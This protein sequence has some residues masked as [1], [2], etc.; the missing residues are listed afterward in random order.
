M[1]ERWRMEHMGMK[2]FS[3]NEMWFWLGALTGII[4]AILLEMLPPVPT[5]V[6]LVLIG[7][8]LW[9]LVRLG[10]SV[11]RMRNGSENGCDEEER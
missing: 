8:A 7:I 10:V 3:R 1:V 4:T 11:R 2:P 6:S 5:L 9:N